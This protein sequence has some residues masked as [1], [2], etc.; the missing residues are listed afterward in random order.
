LICPS[1][2]EF[3]LSIFHS[4]EDLIAA[5][6]IDPAKVTRTALPNAASITGMTLT[7]AAMIAEIE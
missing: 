7:T 4:Y 2:P 1:A 6:V 3:P 5:G